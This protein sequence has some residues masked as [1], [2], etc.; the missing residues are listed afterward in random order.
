MFKRSSV[1]IKGISESEQRNRGEKNHQINYQ[2]FPEL[3]DEFLVERPLE[4]PVQWM[5][6]FPPRHTI[7][8]IQ[9]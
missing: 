2:Y 7:I 8:K 9:H 5:K 6:I 4:S 1:Q 3:N